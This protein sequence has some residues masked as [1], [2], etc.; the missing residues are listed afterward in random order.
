MSSQ[1]P[2]FRPVSTPVK[3]KTM[4]TMTLSSQSITLKGHHG[5]KTNNKTAAEVTGGEKWPSVASRGRAVSLI[6]WL[7]ETQ[8]IR[9]SEFGSGVPVREL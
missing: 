7:A 4:I 3:N 2:T 6:R 5:M 8:D 9:A 1:A